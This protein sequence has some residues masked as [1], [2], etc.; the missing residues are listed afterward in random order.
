[1][2]V[3]GANYYGERRVPAGLLN[4]AA[5]SAGR[6][7]FWSCWAKVLRISWRRFG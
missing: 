1:M 3:W 7:S 2:V 5:L 4:V 6:R